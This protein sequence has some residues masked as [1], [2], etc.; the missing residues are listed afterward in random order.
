MVR[1]VLKGIFLYFSQSED[2]SETD[3]LAALSGS[4]IKKSEVSTIV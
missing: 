2:F 4:P 3:V 1:L